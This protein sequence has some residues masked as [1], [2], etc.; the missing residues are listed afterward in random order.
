MLFNQENPVP[1]TGEGKRGEHGY[2]GYLLRQAAQAHRS[3]VETCLTPTG[4]TLPQFSV[5]TMLHAYPGCSNADLARLSLLTP[6]TVSLIVSNLQKAGTIQREKHATH[7]RIQQI[8]LTEHGLTLLQAARA[9]VMQAEQQMM[10]GFSDDEQ[11]TV[12]RWLSQVALRLSATDTADV[13]QNSHATERKEMQFAEKLAT[14]PTIDHLRG[15]RLKNGDLVIAEILNQPGSAGSVRV[16]HALFQQFGS[17][18]K[19]A[20]EAGITWYAEHTADAH[21]HPGKHPNIDRLIAISAGQLPA[22]QVELIAA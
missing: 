21:Q 11:S 20:A 18:S 14:L 13:L 1:R 15:L 8:A 4:L 9:Q 5:L 16:Y 12:R 10:A 19:E 17:I 6:Q 2:A 22:L 7:G 3:Y